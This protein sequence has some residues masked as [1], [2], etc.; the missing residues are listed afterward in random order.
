[1][2]PF[3]RNWKCLEPLILE[4]Q[5]LMEDFLRDFDFPH[6]MFPSKNIVSNSNK[7][8]DQCKPS[9]VRHKAKKEKEQ[10]GDQ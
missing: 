4:V 9:F 3:V 6:E 10:D 2:C 5:Q 7:K 8:T 1:M